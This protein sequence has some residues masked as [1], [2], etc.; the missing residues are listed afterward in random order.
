MATW[1]DSAWIGGTASGTLYRSVVTT[2][3]LW[4]LE[5]RWV[6]SR[7]HFVTKSLQG[8]TFKVKY[9]DPTLIFT[10]LPVL[11]HWRPVLN[12]KSQKRWSGFGK[13]RQFF[14]GFIA[15]RITHAAPLN[16]ATC[17]GTSWNYY[18]ARFTVHCD[19]IHETTGLYRQPTNMRK[20]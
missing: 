14:C 18:C 17:R 8:G 6:K 5:M 20:F 12:R 15:K 2:Q 3:P 16:F 10:R 9:P 4:S 11:S 7:T 19:T 1:Y 13:F